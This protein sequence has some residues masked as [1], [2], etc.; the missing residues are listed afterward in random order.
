MKKKRET[1]RKTGNEGAVFHAFTART[2]FPLKACA[3]NATKSCDLVALPD[4]SAGA[5]ENWGLI[6]FREGLLLASGLPVPEETSSQLSIIAHELSHQWFGNMVTMKD[7]GEVWLNEGFA[8]FFETAVF[9]NKND[10]DLHRS[11]HAEISFDNALENDCF[12]TS[13]PLSSVIDTPSEIFESFDSI[14]Y[15]KGGAIIDMTAKI[16]GRQKFRKGLNHYIRKFSLRNTQGDDWWRS[17]DE[18]LE[19]DKEHRDGGPDGGVLKMWY[20]GSQW[21]KQMGF[22][23]VTLETV[24]STTIKIG[25]QRFLKGSYALELQKYRFPSYRYKWDVPLFCQEGRQDLGMKWLK[26][27]RNTNKVGVMPLLMG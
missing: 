1:H 22:P 11:L 23:L 12:A 2:S 9:L 27:G 16:M 24:N 15:D 18:S 20:F 4:F 25:Q 6:T 13:R 19:E 3:L 5:M 10:G 7:W 26:R 21:T 8:N 17:I 14:T